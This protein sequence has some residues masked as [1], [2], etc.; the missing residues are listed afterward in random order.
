MSEEAVQKHF[1]EGVP[2][3]MA[4]KIAVEYFSS[5][6]QHQ[7]LNLA[8][9]EIEKSDDDRYW[10]ITLGYTMPRGALPL[11]ALGANAPRSYKLIKINA[12]TGEPISMKIRD[13]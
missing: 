6:F 9:E 8:V 3:D 10:L 2:V 1:P 11:S 5:F 13:L 7:F 4:V 12:E